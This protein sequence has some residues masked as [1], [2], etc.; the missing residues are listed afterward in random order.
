LIRSWINRATLLQWRNQTLVQPPAIERNAHAS[1]ISVF[2]LAKAN[3]CR[4]SQIGCR[5]KWSK[6]LRDGVQQAGLHPIPKHSKDY[7]DNLL[8]CKMLC[9][10][11]GQ[12]T[13]YCLH[14]A[15]ANWYVTEVN[16]RRCCC[17]NKWNDE[18]VSFISS[19]IILIYNRLFWRRVIA[20]QK[21]YYQ[22]FV[23]SSFFSL[24]NP[25]SVHHIILDLITLIALDELHKS[26]SS[27]T[28]SH[29]Q[30]RL[31]FGMYSRAV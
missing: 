28:I 31:W 17:L 19:I 13:L 1:S 27:S 8:G 30:H 15:V 11:H 6:L 14:I 25:I 3:V 21:I 22:E 10:R 9:C 7:S 2:L 23:C 18:P 4:E 12:S 29:P 24:P 20:I 26:W 16:F 5:P